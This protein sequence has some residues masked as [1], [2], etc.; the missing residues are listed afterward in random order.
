MTNIWDFLLQTLSVSLTAILLW[1]VKRI[2]EDKLSP[3]WQYG[4]WSILAL[5]ILIPVQSSRY[6]LP[7]L[8]LWTEALKAMI[9]SGA[10]TVV[11]ECVNDGHNHI[12][13]DAIRAGVFQFAINQQE[14]LNSEG[15][16][17]KK[18]E[19]TGGWEQIF[20]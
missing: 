8:A 16:I 9:E 6:I 7:K 17:F 2:F 14:E 5:R 15:F 13:P 12:G 3:R 1:I 18:A 11:V 19:G 10:N 4:I 20:P